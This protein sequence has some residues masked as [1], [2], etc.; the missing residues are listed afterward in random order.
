MPDIARE[1]LIEIVRRIQDVDPEVDYYVDLF[2][3][4]I[5]DPR[6]SGLI[7]WPPEELEDATPEEIVDV[8]LSY[9]PIEL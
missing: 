9:R 2:E 4:N 3:A 7:Y 8:A 1:E 6:G 5:L